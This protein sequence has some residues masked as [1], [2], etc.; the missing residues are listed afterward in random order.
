M[1]M[2]IAGPLRDRD[3]LER[4]FWPKVERQSAGSQCWLWRAHRNRQGYGII[5]DRGRYISAHRA[6]YQLFVGEIAA[7]LVI[8][9][10]CRNTSCVNPDHLEPVTTRENALRGMTPTVVIRRRGI[11]KNGH[12]I[13]GA[14][15]GIY[16]GRPR[17]R[18]CARSYH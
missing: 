6:S 4:R 17:C 15:R 5:R 16:G 18:T 10:L 14:N 7:G 8:D 2:P 3:A 1:T 12:A 9:H 13:R 11:C